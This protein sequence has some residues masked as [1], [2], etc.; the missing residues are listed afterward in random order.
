MEFSK[1]ADQVVKAAVEYTADKGFEYVTPETILL[2]LCKDKDF[3]DA[4][5]NCDGN[6][7]ELENDLTGYLEKYMERSSDGS[8]EPSISAG[9]M[10]VRAELGANSSEAKEIGISH[11][12]RGLFALKENYGVYYIKKQG[13]G[14]VEL[15][16]AIAEIEDEDLA[17]D[18]ILNDGENEPVSDFGQNHQNRGPVL[19]SGISDCFRSGADGVA[20]HCLSKPFY[21]L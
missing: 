6:I 12:I 8:V 9:E 14:E 17:S 7:K 21:T 19:F 20:I 10:L 1:Q 2:F 5:T 13:I 15:L 4:F 18:A 11:L 16:R 3:S